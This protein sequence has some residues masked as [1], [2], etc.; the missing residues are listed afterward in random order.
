MRQ[1]KTAVSN[2]GAGPV[3]WTFSL[4]ALGLIFIIVFMTGCGGGGSSA[5]KA[6]GSADFT[7]VGS[8]LANGQCETLQESST[9]TSWLIPD[10]AAR[11]R[12]TQLHTRVERC[13]D[14]DIVYL[15]ASGL[16]GGYYGYD[17]K[18]LSWPKDLSASKPIQYCPPQYQTLLNTPCRIGLAF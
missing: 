5:A 16:D 7:D 3:A 6:D 10:G 1:L 13:K 12:L 8:N 14:Y 9:L 18:D 2:W 4:Y 15:R 17:L 11:T